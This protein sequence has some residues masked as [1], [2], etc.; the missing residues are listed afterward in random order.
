MEHS[1]THGHIVPYGTFLRVWFVLLGL[2]ALLVLVSELEHA[3]L[4]VPAML[5]VTP[6]KAG[7]VMYFFMHLKYEKTLLKGMLFIALA[8][9]V[10][11]IG[12]LFLD[13]SFR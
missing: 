9:M 12:M 3:A 11:F 13:I 8:A 5:T 10:I 1:E 2:T 4:S 6:F 7:L